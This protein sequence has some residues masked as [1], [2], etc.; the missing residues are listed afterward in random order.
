MPPESP[1]HIASLVASPTV[2]PSKSIRSLLRH[3]R[4]LS[5]VFPAVELTVI[6]SLYVH[7]SI[8]IR[9]TRNFKG[10]YSYNKDHI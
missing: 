1:V 9:A 10:R 5:R 3:F 6:L 7:T 4:K 2:E 8:P